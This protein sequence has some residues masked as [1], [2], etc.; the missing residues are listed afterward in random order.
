M[1]M[2]KEKYIPAKY[3]PKNPPIL[4]S[5][6]WPTMMHYWGAPAWSYGVIG[7]LLLLLWITY[8]IWLWSREE[9]K[10]APFNCQ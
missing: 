4:A 5:C 10:D 7:T 3:L 2:K 9:I 1:I 6:V 8:F